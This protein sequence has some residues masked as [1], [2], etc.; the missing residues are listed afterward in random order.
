[1]VTHSVSTLECWPSLSPEGWRDTYA[2]LHMWTQ[3]AG[4]GRLKQ[5]YVKARRIYMIPTVKIHG[6]A[7]LFPMP[8]Q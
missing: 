6:T 1:M 5:R 7:H 8:L 4:M 3:I 2:T